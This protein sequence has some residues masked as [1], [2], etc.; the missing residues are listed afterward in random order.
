MNNLSSNPCLGCIKVSAVSGGLELGLRKCLQA[1]GRLHHSPGTR[2]KPKEEKARSVQPHIHQHHSPPHIHKPTQPK[3]WGF[4]GSR[5]GRRPRPYPRRPKSRGRRKERREPREAEPENRPHLFGR[6]LLLHQLRPRLRQGSLNSRT[7]PRCQGGRGGTEPQPRDRGGEREDVKRES[8][9]P[10]D[11]Q[12]SS[13]ASLYQEWTLE[14][15]SQHGG[16]KRKLMSPADHY[17][18]PQPSGKQTSVNLF[19]G[20]PGKG[21]S[22]SFSSRGGVEVTGRYADMWGEF[23]Y[24][25][26]KDTGYPGGKKSPGISK[27]LSAGVGRSIISHL[28]SMQGTSSKA[29]LLSPEA[30]Q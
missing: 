21:H 11:Q 28:C 2:F 9:E 1:P 25:G 3:P 5:E 15:R 8:R 22:E 17:P 4:P 24:Q 6:G 20:T 18:S 12:L 19:G 23:Q 14:R 7:S 29:E 16:S 13:P 26:W 30:E 10:E 27:P